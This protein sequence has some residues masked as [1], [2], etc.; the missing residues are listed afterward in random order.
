MR[1]LSASHLQAARA[2]V[3][4]G[5]TKAQNWCQVPFC[6]QE[7]SADDGSGGRFEP[8][9][10]PLALP[11]QR[12]AGWLAGQASER[13]ASRRVGAT[14]AIWMGALSCRLPAAI[15]GQAGGLPGQV[16]RRPEKVLALP[17]ELAAA[18]WAATREPSGRSGT[19]QFVAAAL[20]PARA[21]WQSWPL[22]SN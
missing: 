10:L 4:A 9:H 7:Q 11:L 15:V 20:Q 8:L 2:R 16:S 3:G 19:N 18:N 5:A 22:A 6:Q 14:A 17:L 21:S 13:A 1:S 12:P